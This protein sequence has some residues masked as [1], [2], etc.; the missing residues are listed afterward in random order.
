MS[1]GQ[2]GALGKPGGRVLVAFRRPISLCNCNER[3]IE[4]QNMLQPALGQTFHVR[5]GAEFEATF[6]RLVEFGGLK[7]QPGKR[8]NWMLSSLWQSKKTVAA[9]SCA[10]PT[11]SDLRASAPLIC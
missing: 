4:P 10:R 5:I 2:P 8:P 3:A 11:S 6:T 9:L 1:T 7:A